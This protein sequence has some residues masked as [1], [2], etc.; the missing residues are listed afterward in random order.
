VHN[1]FLEGDYTYF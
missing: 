1:P